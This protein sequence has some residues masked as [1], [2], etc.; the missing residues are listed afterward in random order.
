MLTE[1]GKQPVGPLKFSF[2][3]RNWLPSASHISSLIF[4]FTRGLT[5]EGKPA[6]G[7]MKST[8]R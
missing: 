3:R 7:N 8:N 1:L 2:K 5:Y 4:L 6:V